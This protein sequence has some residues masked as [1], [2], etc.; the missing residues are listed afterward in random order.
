MTHRAASRTRTYLIDFDA[1]VASSRTSAEVQQKMKA[2]YGRLGLEM[3]LQ[4]GAD[5]AFAPK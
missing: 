5:A 4:L 1:A 3:V 2:K